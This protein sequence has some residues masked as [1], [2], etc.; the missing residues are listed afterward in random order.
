[1]LNL[2]IM[3]VSFSSRV[4]VPSGTLINSTGGESVLLNVNSETYF[5]LDEVGTRMW[6]ALT[7][8][9][10]VQAAYEAL[11]DEYDVDAEVLRR[12]LLELIDQ[13]LEQGLIE[14]SDN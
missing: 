8:L 6:A 3:A 4:L 10:S 11:L 14:V 7:T 5:G 12:D 9:Q 2:R 13:C 1:M